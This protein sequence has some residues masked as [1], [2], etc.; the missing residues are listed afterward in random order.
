MKIDPFKLTEACER[1]GAALALPAGV[2]GAAVLQALAEVESSYG[3][4]AVPKHEPAYDRGGRYFSPTLA[5][6][7]G[8]WAAC[9]YGPFQ[10]MFPVFLEL[11]IHVT[12]VSACDL[13]PGAKA[14]AGII[15]KRIKRQIPDGADAETVVR[16][17]GD[18]YNSGNARDKNVPT[19]YCDKLWAAYRRRAARYAP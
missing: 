6:G 1:E 5:R 12:P 7:W 10:V 19:A 13:E 9:S 8:S 2:N 18:A 11:G 3:A 15:A 17:I 16:T 4:N 14:A